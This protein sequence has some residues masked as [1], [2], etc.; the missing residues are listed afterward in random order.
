MTPPWTSGCLQIAE[1]GDTLSPKE[2]KKKVLKPSNKI[3][4]FDRSGVAG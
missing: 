4:P 3:E 2:T 1:I